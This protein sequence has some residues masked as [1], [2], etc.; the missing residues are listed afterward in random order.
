MD[1]RLWIWIGLAVFLL[2]MV[3]LTIWLFRMK[4]KNKMPI[5]YFMWFVIGMTWI[6]IGIPFHNIGLV[7]MGI[8]FMIVSLVNKKEWKK[9]H[10]MKARCDTPSLATKLSIIVGILIILGIILFILM[11]R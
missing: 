6:I 7:F 4:R 5:D 9:N 3:L 8:I 10:A 2:L 11:R 1:T